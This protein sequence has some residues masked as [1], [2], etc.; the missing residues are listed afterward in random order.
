MKIM[1]IVAM[2]FMLQGCGP[3]LFWGVTTY[4]GRFLDNPPKVEDDRR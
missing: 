4:N 1:A 2:T 3:W